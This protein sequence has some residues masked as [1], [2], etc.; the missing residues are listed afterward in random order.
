MQTGDQ[1]MP[2]GKRRERIESGEGLKVA[3]DLAKKLLKEVLKKK[4]EE[5]KQNGRWR[6]RAT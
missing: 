3:N 5:E 4:K 2:F 1:L 6:S